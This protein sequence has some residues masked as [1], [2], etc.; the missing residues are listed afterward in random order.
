[1]NSVLTEKILRLEHQPLSGEEIDTNELNFKS[2]KVI[3]I[4]DV[5]VGKTCL[6]QRLVQDTFSKE[7]P[8]TVGVEFFDY[9]IKFKGGDGIK[10]AVW[11]TAGQENFRS[12]TR[13]FYKD[14]DAVFLIFNITNRTSFDNL[15]AWL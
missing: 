15:K 10:L 4:G 13:L 6:I 7:E 5:S 2:Y 1:M 9:W 14:S 12:I 8:T 3:V 11:D